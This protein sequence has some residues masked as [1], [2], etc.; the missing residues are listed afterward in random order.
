MS[1]AKQIL[2]VS[3]KGFVYGSS[4]PT[5]PAKV[6]ALNVGWF[7]N[8]NF[9]RSPGMN[10]SLPYTPMIWG[11]TSVNNPMAVSL[12]NQLNNPGYENVVLGFN[13]PDGAKQANMTVDQAIQNWALLV[14]TGRRVGSPATASNPTKAG[15]WFANFMT[16]AKAGGLRVD[17]IA[18][19]WY[20]PPNVAS[21]LNEL[22]TLYQQYNLPIW[23]TEFA[24][25]DWTATTG[26]K[27]T[28]D[29]VTA[30]MK[31][32]VP[33]LNKRPYIERFAWKTRATSDVNMGTS[34]L[35]NDD[36][37]LTALGVVYASL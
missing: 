2:P 7:Y 28:V 20:A 19:H 26:S 29:D 37:S 10:T 25:A 35:F 34:A 17:F 15:S 6:G 9:V 14:N 8:W 27:F 23:I 21:F 16:A 13:E 1:T 4:D 5:T 30:F 24:V 33:E 36:G 18:V 22:D 3:K 31:A 32:V 12:I 11:M